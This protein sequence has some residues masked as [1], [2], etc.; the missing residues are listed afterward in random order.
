LNCLSTCLSTDRNT[1]LS[2]LRMTSCPKA[3]KMQSGALRTETNTADRLI[4]TIYSTVTA[5][6]YVGLLRRCMKASGS[7]IREME[8]VVQSTRIRLHM[9]ETLCRIKSMALANTPGPTGMC[10]RVS[11]IKTRSTVQARRP[12]PV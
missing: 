10:T 9:R 12:T 1:D 2:F 3:I 6:S 4:W 5:F 7:S 8:G 11:S